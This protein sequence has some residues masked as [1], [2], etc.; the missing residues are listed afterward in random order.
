VHA[1]SN[2][3]L[4]L[5]HPGLDLS[6]SSL[7][8]PSEGPS[9]R[10]QCSYTSIDSLPQISTAHLKEFYSL[11]KIKDSSEHRHRPSILGIFNLYY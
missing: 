11:S 9:V 6:G 1:D 5:Y 2:L 8:Y 7:D 4:K 3:S 10:T